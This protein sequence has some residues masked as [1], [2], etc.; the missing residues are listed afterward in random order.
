MSEN[1]PRLLILNQ[2]A[3]PMTW[4]LAE[5]A[6]EALG[7]VAMLT[8]HPETLA[9]GGTD[10]VQLHPAASYVRGSFPQRAL[11]WL[12]YALQAFFWRALAAGDGCRSGFDNARSR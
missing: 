10:K 12:H 7:C 8:G 9:K 11:S 6:G 3:G 1:L 5:D 2:M 4:E